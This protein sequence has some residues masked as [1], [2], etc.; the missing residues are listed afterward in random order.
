MSQLT[1]SYSTS[2]RMRNKVNFGERPRETDVLVQRTRPVAPAHA[3]TYGFRTQ[4][5][6][7][8]KMTPICIGHTDVPRTVFERQGFLGPLPVLTGGNASYSCDTLI[9]VNTSRLPSGR[10][11]ERSPI[12]CFTT[13]LLS[14]SSSECFGCCLGENIIL[15]GACVK[16]RQPRQIHPWHT[17]IE[18][19]RADMRSVSIWIGIE[20]TSRDS[21]LQLIS[22]SHR[23]GYTI[24]ELVK[25]HGLRRGDASSQMIEAWSKEI[26][27]SARFVKPD[28]VD[29]EAI[30]FDGRL[31]HGTE[32]G[33][34]D[35]RT[36]VLLQY[37]AADEK[38]RLPDLSQLEWPFRFRSER[39]PTIVIS[40][41]APPGLNEVE[42]APVLSHSPQYCMCC[43]SQKRH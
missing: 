18:T 42:K 23:F 6:I 30:I 32:N 20:N 38:I 39:P 1:L 13:L 27:R 9:E 25:Q 28:M 17:D 29:G 22:G 31:W 34:Q 36:A 4:S 21:S 3:H 35:K 33:R 40:G 14:R 7:R 16:A 24:Q 2:S 43:M 12:I 41:A 10:K 19:S 26:D 37:A 15:W 5:P 8:K 11:A